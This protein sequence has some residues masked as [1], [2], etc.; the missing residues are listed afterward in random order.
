[1]E[2]N[3][4]FVFNPECLA[5]KKK[6]TSGQSVIMRTQNTGVEFN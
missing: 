5:Q 3:K 4:H 6:M 1:M 2:Q